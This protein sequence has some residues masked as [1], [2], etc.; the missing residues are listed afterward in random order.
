MVL[1]PI[2]NMKTNV[3]SLLSANFANKLFHQQSV[4]QRGVVHI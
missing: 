3:V 1:T 2:S 4:H